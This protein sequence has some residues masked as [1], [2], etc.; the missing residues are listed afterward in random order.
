[1]NIFLN[2]DGQ[3]ALWVLSFLGLS[4]IA[5]RSTS[6]SVSGWYSLLEKPFLTPPDIIFPIVWTFLYVLIAAAGWLLWRERNNSAHSLHLLFLFALQ[7]MMNWGWSFIFFTLHLLGFAVIWIFALIACVVL[8]ILG[9]RKAERRV[10]ILLIPYLVW[11]AFA[12]YLSAG[13]WFLN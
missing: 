8:L 12:A 10:T 6:E 11:L 5:A 1:M 4:W 2:R 3:L 13:I 7:A 9:A